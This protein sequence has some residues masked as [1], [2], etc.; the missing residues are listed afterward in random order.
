[1]TEFEF[2][3]AILQ[4][5]ADATARYAEP[6]IVPERCPNPRCVRGQVEVRDVHSGRAA[7]QRCSSCCGR[8][9]VA[10]EAA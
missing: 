9:Y 8:G 1:M 2:M 5:H 10:R 6:G 7:L 4:Q 3:S